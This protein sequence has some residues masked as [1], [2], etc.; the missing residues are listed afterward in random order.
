MTDAEIAARALACLD[1]TDLGRG[2]GEADIER[3]CARAETPHGDVAAVCTWAEHA[4]YAKERL[5]NSRV[6][7]AVVA[8]FP[9]GGEQVAEAVEEVEK[10]VA[11]EADEIDI[12]LPY[13]AFAEGRADVAAKMIDGARMAASSRVLKVIL[14]TGML[15]EPNLIRRAAELAI[16]EGADFVKTSTGKTDTGATP[17]AAREMLD[18]IE[19]A[20]RPAGLKV[21]GGVRTVDDARLYLELAEKRMGTGWARATT[22][23]IGASGLLTE[24]METLDGREAAEAAGDY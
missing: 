7:V 12:V 3:L 2:C 24:L 23:R 13:R 10:A 11:D 22:F 14:E 1:L 19:A 17:E 9:D 15:R 6:H 16:G 4:A 20:S 18:A 8:N 21:S 5:R